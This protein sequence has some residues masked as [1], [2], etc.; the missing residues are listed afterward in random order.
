MMECFHYSIFLALSLLQ[1]LP[2]RHIKPPRAEGA[3]PPLARTIRDWLM[4]PGSTARLPGLNN[5]LNLQFLSSISLLLSPLQP[6]HRNSV[7][8]L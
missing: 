5:P 8:E 1:L 4:A 6:W 3:D 2:R 7:P